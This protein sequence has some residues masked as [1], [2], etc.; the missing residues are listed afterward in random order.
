MLTGDNSGNKNRV[1]G[2]SSGRLQFEPE[3]T[4]TKH[5]SYLI[6]L[7]DRPQSATEEELLPS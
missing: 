4:L 1:L 2:N 7:G 5:S 3:A 6:D